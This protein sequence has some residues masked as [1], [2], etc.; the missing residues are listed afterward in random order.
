M[1][2][3]WMCPGE[4]E[5]ILKFTET[6]SKAFDNKKKIE[7]LLYLFSEVVFIQLFEEK[8]KKNTTK[9]VYQM[10][11]FPL[12]FFSQSVYVKQRKKQFQLIEF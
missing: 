5:R 1:G 9:I 10:E 6:L 11:I 7:Q 2:I 8:Q 12:F 3:K 4:L